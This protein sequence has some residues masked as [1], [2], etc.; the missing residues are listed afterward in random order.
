M[1]TLPLISYIV[2]IVL[3]LV[4]IAILTSQP[5]IDR[6][7]KR[8]SLRKARKVKQIRDEVRRYLDELRES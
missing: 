3:V 7:N 4:V 1:Q 6:Y 8:K 5:M 2:N